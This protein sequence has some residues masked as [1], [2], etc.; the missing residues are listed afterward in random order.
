LYKSI[1]ST[2]SINLI[3]V[4]LKELMLFL[5][6]QIEIV[7]FFLKMPYLHSCFFGKKFSAVTAN[8]LIDNPNYLIV[9]MTW[10]V[11]S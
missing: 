8:H 2:S 3:Y 9:W 11:R 10:T 4:S 1:S 5:F 6:S 7:I